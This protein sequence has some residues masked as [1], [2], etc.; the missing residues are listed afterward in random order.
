MF[1]VQAALLN[2]YFPSTLVNMWFVAKKS[3]I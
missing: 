2:C 3:R 1:S